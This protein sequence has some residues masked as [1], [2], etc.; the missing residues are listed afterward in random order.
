MAEVMIAPLRGKPLLQ[1]VKELSDM[2]RREVARECGYYTETRKGD[3][4]I[5]LAEFYEALLDARGI[6]LDSE[7][8]QKRGREASYRISVQKNGQIL[9]GAA[10]TKEM[11]LKP[12]D[13]FDVK[14]GYKHIHLYQNDEATANDYDDDDED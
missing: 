4:R 1:K 10:Y 9:I 14:L 3:T 2:S 11:G 6:S 7:S 12:G 8:G 5:N 13:V